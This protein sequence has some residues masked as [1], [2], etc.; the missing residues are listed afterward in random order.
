MKDF[1]GDQ[2]YEAV[3]PYPPAFNMEPL[4]I[5]GAYF[6]S[7]V[8]NRYQPLDSIQHLYTN[9]GPMLDAGFDFPWQGVEY[10]QE[11]SPSSEDS[12]SGGVSSSN[13]SYD[14]DNGRSHSD[15]PSPRTPTCDTESTPTFFSF[16]NN[17]NCIDYGAMPDLHAEFPTATAT[18]VSRSLP[19]P[20]TCPEGCK[21]TFG[22]QY[23]LKRHLV[24]QHQCPYEECKHVRFRTS[25]EKKEHERQH[26]KIGLGY[27]CGTCE[28]GGMPPK[29]LSR[30]EKLKKHLKDTHKAPASMDYRD[31]SCNEM[32]CYLGKDVGGVFFASRNDLERHKQ[33]EHGSDSSLVAPLNDKINRADCPTPLADNLASYN[34]GKRPLDQFHMSQAKRGKLQEGVLEMPQRMPIP[35]HEQAAKPVISH[36]I[37]GTAATSVSISASHHP[38]ASLNPQIDTQLN[39][40]HPCKQ[41]EES[42]ALSIVEVQALT[43]QHELKSV[44]E[45]LSALNIS[46]TF[47]CRSATIKLHG[48]C[49]AD[50]MARGKM[51]LQ[52]LIDN[53]RST[54]PCNDEMIS[55]GILKSRADLQQQVSVHLQPE[56]SPLDAEGDA[57]LI[58]V[59]NDH[60]LP[61]FPSIIQELSVGDSYSI[62]LVRQKGSD[63]T[64]PIVR[65]RS[66][67]NQ[68]K[69]SRRIIKDA[70]KEICV[71]NNCTVLNVQFSRG[72]IVR[73]VGGS[74]SSSHLDDPSNDDE[75][76]PHQR[77]PWSV[78]GMGASIGMI[79][80]NDISATLGGYIWVDGRIYMLSV[81]HF[82]F[83]AG[84]CQCHSKSRR[85]RSPSISDIRDIRYRLRRKLK[86]LE[87]KIMRS[88]PRGEIPLGQV[89]ELFTL[90]TNEELELYRRFESELNTKDEDFALGTIRVRCGPGPLPLSPSA[91]PRLKGKSHRMDWSLFQ[92][93][94]KQREGK[95]IHR[96]RRI[97]QP[98][99]DDLSNELLEPE[100]SGIPVEKTSNIVGG[101]LCHYVGT[102]SGFREGRVNPAL[103]QFCERE[104]ISHEY[105]MI[106]PGCEG[107]RASA[108][109]GDSGAWIIGNEHNTL[110]GLL[111]GWDNGSLLFT[112]IQDVFADIKRKMNCHQV[113]LP[114]SSTGPGPHE[115]SLLCRKNRPVS[116][117]CT[118]E[119][120][121]TPAK[122]CKVTSSPLDK[123]D[124]KPEFGVHCRT[125]SSCSNSSQRSPSP[126]PSLDS[127]VSSISDGVSPI[128]SPFQ[129]LD[130]T[131]IL[132]SLAL[133]PK[134]KPRSEQTM[135]EEVG[136]E[137]HL[138][139][140][141]DA[142]PLEKPSSWEKDSQLECNPQAIRA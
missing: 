3:D 1:N 93:T 120:E 139:Q 68:D 129:L 99:L 22:R 24:E 85:L 76:F 26:S 30:G 82:I 64:H 29:P 69:E 116:R 100:G 45:R 125:A 71:R 130:A 8:H 124:L 53:S 4:D 142:V 122:L 59:W 117:A 75:P 108:F 48:T 2:E 118:P 109:E 95:N 83:P 131:V 103:I 12:I 43:L 87:K 140:R 106:V 66:S 74:S 49:S 23:E 97:S 138:I 31:F 32:P 65:F 135:S 17:T 52:E 111:W 105:S 54:T 10:P 36:Q 72:T 107:L 57:N 78:P 102:T 137:W 37:A 6:D 73:L 9:S 92:I 134:D 104:N 98:G 126:V 96:H 15:E 47:D 41:T 123:I 35:S 44:L 91:N 38:L 88:A 136:G 128:Q 58:D 77:R 28:L 112:P 13:T 25:Q 21:R 114:E 79:Q 63:G 90:Q 14:C 50:Q 81:D 5:L 121:P 70:I 11:P 7:G 84:E 27:R 42:L 67:D 113:K 115:F 133:R 55:S 86:E 34:I 94:E 19:E 20:F 56:I 16:H 40:N 110:L 141:E 132:E 51:L 80:C 89:Y 127:S 119:L 60:I 39:L 62:A 46:P 33:Q 18:A 61:K 101:E